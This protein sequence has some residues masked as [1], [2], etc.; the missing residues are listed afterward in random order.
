MRAIVFDVTELHLRRMDRN[1]TQPSN[2]MEKEESLTSPWVYAGLKHRSRL[3][4]LNAQTSSTA[5]LNGVLEVCTIVFSVSRDD[6]LGSCRKQEFAMG[7]HAFVKLARD[8]T[9]ESYTMI[10][11]YLGKRN[12]ATALNSYRRAS[13]LIDTYPLFRDRHEMC[14]RLLQKADTIREAYQLEKLA[15]RIN[16]VRKFKVDD[17]DI[18][19]KNNEKSIKYKEPETA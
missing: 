4:V 15:N 16:L 19:Y 6:I 2:N 8:R 5:D 11:D 12:H 17:N 3:Y 9:N 14:V 13:D 7:R 1:K 10:A 18:E